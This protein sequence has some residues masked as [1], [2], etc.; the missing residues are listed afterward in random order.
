MSIKLVRCSVGGLCLFFAGSL[1]HAEGPLDKSTIDQVI[2][3]VDVVDAATLSET[4][5]VKGEIFN[6]PDLIKTGRKSRAQLRADDGTLTRVGSNTVFSFDEQSRTIN[7]QQGN[8]LFNS[9]KGQGGGKIVTASASATVLG[10][11]LVV[12]ATSNGGFKTMCLEGQ[13]SIQFPNGVTQTLNPG[14]MTF[15]LPTPGAAGA[16]PSAVGGEDGNSDPGGEPGPVVNFDLE[17]SVEGS[18][19]VNGFE[20]ALPSIGTIQQEIQSQNEA[21]ASGDLG[22]TGLAVIDAIS[23]GELVVVDG[24]LLTKAVETVTESTTNPLL[25]AGLQND[26]TITNAS[27]ISSTH[28]LKGTTSFSVQEIYTTLFTPDTTVDSSDRGLSYTTKKAYYAVLGNNITLVGV[29]DGSSSDISLSDFSGA[30]EVLIAAKATLTVNPSTS[31]L[32][33]KGLE[34][35]GGLFVT[36]KSLAGMNNKYVYA[37]FPSSSGNRVFGVYIADNIVLTSAGLSNSYGSLE[38]FSEKGITTTNSTFT[39]SSLVGNSSAP[40][41]TKIDSHGAISLTEGSVT[42]Y[43]V[44]IGATDSGNVTLSGSFTLTGGNS[45][46]LRTPGT[47]TVSSGSTNTSP[48]PVPSF[49]ASAKVI[50]MSNHNLHAQNIQIGDV[51]SSIRT[52]NITLNMVTIQNATQVALSAQTVTLYGVSFPNGSTVSLKSSMGQANFP[53]VMSGAATGYVNFVGT[54]NSWGATQLISSNYNAGTK[55]FTGTSVT[56]GTR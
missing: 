50:S 34:N 10:T 32:N 48:S 14:Q 2:N 46:T 43:N 33:L 45:M 9:P 39:G 27:N 42:G 55:T 21:I 15:I 40:N 12:S 35:V 20:G 56:V 17:A 19:L 6:A 13:V 24:D 49:A 28:I 4:P 54:G 29:P 38:L 47:L 22:E 36:A 31:Y 26:L 11:T 53:S 23:Q 52:D 18:A 5:A 3:Q 51:D 8:I 44:T 30:S 7:L 41:F 1:L 16:Q 25:A 37:E